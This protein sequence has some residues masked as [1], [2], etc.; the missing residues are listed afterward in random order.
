MTAAARLPPELERAI[1]ELAAHTD[2]TAIP[3]LLR[4]AQRVLIWLE[5]LLYRVLRFDGANP[6]VTQLE[7]IKAKP[8][9]FLASAVRHVNFDGNVSLDVVKS[10][11]ES[12]PGI[13]NLG[14]GWEL[15]NPTF[16]PVLGNM[17]IQRLSANLRELFRRDG[18]SAVDL[19]HPMFNSVTH[20]E[21][22][23]DLG[24]KT[25]VW[26]KRLS[27]LSTLT[28]LSFSPP[29]G[30]NLPLMQNILAATPRIQV[31]LISF[32]FG[33]EEDAR[34]VAAR[35]KFVDARLVVGM[36]GDYRADWERGARGG[37]DQWIRADGFVA[38][39]GAGK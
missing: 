21:L 37:D 3:K 1:F 19:E 22:L 35:I 27:T 11:L 13:V 4:V 28:H 38:R 26:M 23:D 16:S 7:A 34:L 10:I 36:Y 24:T 9:S 31:L 33:E 8:A 29:D 15:G 6:S 30:D 39:K 17:R 5:P 2:R 18:E 12:C 32:F 14:L 20:L 25:E